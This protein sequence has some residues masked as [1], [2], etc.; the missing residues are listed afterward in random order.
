[1][2]PGVNKAYNM[3]SWFFYCKLVAPHDFDMADKLRQI[4]ININIANYLWFLW[5][6]ITCLNRTGTY[7]LRSPS[8]KLQS[9]AEASTR[10]ILY[11]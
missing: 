2:H 5:K 10:H 8:K 1:M 6:N 3:I 4:L 9:S 7:N 11:H